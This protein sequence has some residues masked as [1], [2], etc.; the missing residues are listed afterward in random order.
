MTCGTVIS[1]AFQ[2]QPGVLAIKVWLD[3]EKVVKEIHIED[4]P[5][6]RCIE[7]EDSL[8]WE[9]S[10]VFWSNRQR[11]VRDIEMKRLQ[12]PATKKTET[13]EKAGK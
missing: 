2:I 8:C 12:G 3:R 11:T 9:D 13:K 10:K 5:A 4:C 7:E 1:D 6:A